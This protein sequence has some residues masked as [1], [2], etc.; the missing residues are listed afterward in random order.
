MG[1]SIFLWAMVAI[2]H[3]ATHDVIPVP[4]KDV[5]VINSFSKVVNGQAA[6]HAQFPWQVSIRAT[7]SHSVTVCG[8]SLI[9]PQWVLT[10]AHCAKD[11]TAFQIGFGSIYLNVPR[12]TMSTVTKVVHPG[13]DPVRLNNDLAVIKLPSPVPFSN[14]IQPV[15]LPPVSYATKTFQ[16]VLGRVSGFGRTSDAIQSISSTLKFENMR[17]ISNTECATVYGTSV[18]QNSTMCA[19]GWDQTNQNVCQG[20]SGGP[21]V[22]NDNGVYIQI[23]IVSFV[24]NRGCSTG[25]PSGY[26]RTASYLYWIAEQTGVN[27]RN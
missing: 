16:N 2:A 22:V 5:P 8:G 1:I 21:L 27:L 24:S 6:N 26:I 10:A 7:L 25:D 3:A 23:G 19:L 20:D 4:R 18:I 11:Y 12:L 9:A 15:Q 17:I 13:F 14:E